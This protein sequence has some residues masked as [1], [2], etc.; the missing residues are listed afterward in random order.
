MTCALL[1]A[2]APALAVGQESADRLEL[3]DVFQLEWVSDP[4]IS[5][6]GEQVVYVR[7]FNDIMADTGRSNLWIADVASGEK[8]PLTTGTANDF[9]PRWSPDG[10]KLLYVSTRDG[11]AELWLRWMD[12]G[13]TAKLT[14]LTQSPGSVSWSPDGNW[15]AF[16]MF[17]PSSPEPMANLPAAPP[18]AEWAEPARVMTRLMYR[19]DGA[20]YLPHGFNHVF[21]LSADGGTP[22]QL[23]EGDFNHGGRLSWTPDS[24][25]VVFS[26]NRRD[27]WDPEAAANPAQARLAATASPPGRAP[28][29]KRAARNNAELNPAL[30]ATVPMSRNIGIADKLQCAAKLNG[31]SLA[32]PSAT[33]TLR[34][35]PIPTSATP[36]SAT[37]IGT[38]IAIKNRIAARLRKPIVRELMQLYSRCRDPFARTRLKFA[39]TIAAQSSRS[40]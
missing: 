3:I 2:V 5:P 29:H 35:M 38:R 4:Q 39:P 16:S 34:T 19:A 11:G 22:R 26:A 30:C 18:G 25:A 31:V 23:T 1:L 15:I 10:S 17:V 13:Q 27:D 33:S 28:N 8:R 12:T 36:P 40:R 20:G 24:G 6:D 21:V 32:R 9:S 14:G 37:A 7:N